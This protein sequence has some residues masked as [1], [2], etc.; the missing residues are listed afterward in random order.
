M[1]RQVQR[2]SA[3]AAAT[4]TKAGRHADGGGLYLNVTES[5]A[6]SWVFMWKVAGKRREIGL[7]PLRDVPLGRER[8]LC[9]GDPPESW[10]VEQSFFR[11]TCISGSPHCRQRSQTWPELTEGRAESGINLLLCRS[12]LSACC[13]WTLRGTCAG[14]TRL[15]SSAI[16]SAAWGS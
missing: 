9:R 10:D 4:L 1:A 13:A 3:R 8:E 15:R 2:L 5:G 16:C 12:S 11:P 14:S 6:K 7:G